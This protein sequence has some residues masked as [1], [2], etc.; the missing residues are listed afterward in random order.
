MS[1]KSAKSAKTN[2]VCQSC[3]YHTTKWLGRCP[4]C[5][6]WNTLLEEALAQADAPTPGSAGPRGGAVQALAQVSMEDQARLVTGVSEFDI[7][8]GGGLTPGSVALVGGD[9]GIGK[10][11]LLL[12]AFSHLAAAG[13]RVLYVSGEE[14]PHQ[15]KLR[16][17]R[18]GLE[19]ERLLVLAET[20]LEAVLA[21]VA[22]VE[23]VVLAVD[24][25]QTMW[26]Q[27]IAAAAGSISQLRAVTE[28]LVELAKTKGL[29]CL[30]VGHVT[31]EGVIAGPRALEH[32]VDTVVYFE[33][34]RGHPFRI[35][36]AAKNR[37][38]STD[39][40]GV[41]EMRERG[42]V[43]VANPSALF[44]AERPQDV[45]GSAVVASLEGSRPIL[46]EIQALVSP[47][48]GGSPRRSAL[49]VDHNRLS[50]L[51]AVLEKRGGLELAS[52]D[53]F[54]N[55]AGGVRVTE[56]AADLGIVAAA[57]SSCL[58]RPVD[59]RCV[60]VGEVGLAGEVRGVSHPELRVR[61]AAKMGF[62]RMLL[63]RGS[64]RALKETD[65]ELVGV[66]TIGEVLGVLFE[67]DAPS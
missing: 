24:S 28:R 66:G 39:E 60:L 38:G 23:P 53:I 8:F 45:P 5:R 29:V 40:V 48:G 63:P 36:R 1:T 2:Y 51:M 13:R 67:G 31:K 44:L 34:D 59:P 12:Q 33:G 37:F 52:R 20:S 50:V 27:G 3:G 10:S 11:T 32:M 6:E 62:T 35:L 43:P 26:V 21:A 61:E 46:L 30:L 25:V 49:G 9:P 54:V 16:S 18:L 65:M 17:T 14:S 41:F 7:P 57:A 22:Q 55:V 15:I 56:T 4:Q 64:R 42:L 58:D 47:G 19:E